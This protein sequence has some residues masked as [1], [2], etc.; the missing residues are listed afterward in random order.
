[1]KRALIAAGIAFLFMATGAAAPAPSSARESSKPLVTV[2]KDPDCGCCQKWIAYLK[3]HGFRVNAKDTDKL[4]D[5]NTKLGVPEKL[6]SCHTAVVNGYI[7]EGHVP[8]EDIARLLREKPKVAGLAVPGMPAG[9][10]GMDGTPVHYQVLA[11]D[12]S[13]KT[14]VFASH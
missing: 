11:F 9:A 12:H 14:T 8:V 4:A 6:S 13:G 7:I 10:P 2:Y 5:I 1:M 3:Q